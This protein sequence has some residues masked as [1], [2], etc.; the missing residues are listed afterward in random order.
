MFGHIR[1]SPNTAYRPLQRRYSV[2]SDTSH[3][4]CTLG[5]TTKVSG[6]QV[7]LNLKR[8]KA[9]YL[10]DRIVVGYE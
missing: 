1:Q 3:V 5:Y 10:T 9:A 7:K 8:N 6:Q 2:P 4:N